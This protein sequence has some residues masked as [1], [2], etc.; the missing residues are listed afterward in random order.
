MRVGISP[1]I[2]MPKELPVDKDYVGINLYA[3]VHD[4]GST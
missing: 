2:C 3:A 4:A 1:T